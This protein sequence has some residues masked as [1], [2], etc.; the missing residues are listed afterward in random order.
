MGFLSMGFG[1]VFGYMFFE[2]YIGFLGMGFEGYVGIGFE[3]YRVL[4][5][6][7]WNSSYAF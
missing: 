2:G 7:I 1:R 4:G 6:G 5:Y 3:G